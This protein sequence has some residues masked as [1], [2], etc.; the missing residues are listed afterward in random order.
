MVSEVQ[1]SLLSADDPPPVG[2]TNRG[3]GSLFL[4]LGDHAGNRVPQRLGTLG[5][6][7]EELTRHI[8]LDI[9]VAELGC[10]LAEKLDAPFLKQRYSRLVVDCNRSKGF[11]DSITAISDGILIPGND[12]LPH[13]ACRQRYDE[14]FDPYHREIERMIDQRASQGRMTILV[15]LHSFTPVLSGKVRPRHIGVLYDGGYIRFARDVLDELTQVGSWC[16]G[17]NE[18]YRMDETD[19]TIPRHAYAKGLPYVELEIRQD[20]LSDTHGVENIS[21][22]LVDVFGRSATAERCQLPRTK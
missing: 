11:A 18:P 15:S 13:D 22:L 2:V 19:F 3:G 6:P 16:I 1:Q 20:L 5:L 17:D 7:P 9:G 10:N 21:K 12:R 14:I 8:A 4:L